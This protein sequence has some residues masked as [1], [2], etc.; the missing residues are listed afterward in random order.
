MKLGPM[1]CPRIK[2]LVLTGL[3]LY[4]S[5]KEKLVN[6]MPGVYAVRGPEDAAHSNTL[7]AALAEFLSTFIFVFAGQGS[8]LALGYFLF[9]LLQTSLFSN[10]QKT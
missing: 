9:T 3:S 8:V 5:C 4:R 2:S 6:K 10:H 7:R 1:K